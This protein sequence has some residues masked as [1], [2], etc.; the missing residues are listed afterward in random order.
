MKKE[1]KYTW[2]IYFFR[3]EIGQIAKMFY[4]LRLRYGPKTD[5]Y[6]LCKTDT[7]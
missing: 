2:F 3:L 1:L 7:F 5:K 6:V 4:I